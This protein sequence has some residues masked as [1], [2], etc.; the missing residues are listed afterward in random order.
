MTRL[1]TRRCLLA[2]ATG[3]VL[4]AGCAS[5]NIEQYAAEKPALDLAQYFNG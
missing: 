2:L 1:P 5:Q 4:L 3:T